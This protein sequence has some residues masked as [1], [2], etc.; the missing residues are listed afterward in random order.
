MDKEKL[1]KGAKY[2]GHAVGAAAVA[3]VSGTIGVLLSDQTAIQAALIAAGVN[4]VYIPLAMM[5]VAAIAGY[6]TKSPQDQAKTQS[7]T[8][9]K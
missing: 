6:F 9:A 3:A 1:L 7:G 8:E 4:P 2:A 5:G